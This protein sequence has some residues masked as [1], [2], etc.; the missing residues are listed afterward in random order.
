LKIDYEQIEDCMLKKTIMLL[1]FSILLTMAVFAQR[2]PVITVL[3]FTANGIASSDM[4]AIVSFLS[5]SMFE[6][7]QFEVI[8]KVDIPV[9]TATDSG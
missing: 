7:R 5:S 2:K 1:F 9:K 8:D 3:D 4:N 6:T